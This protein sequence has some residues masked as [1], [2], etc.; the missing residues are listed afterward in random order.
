MLTPAEKEVI[1]KGMIVMW[2]IWS[3]ILLSLFM[4]VLIC[5][6]VGDQVRQHSHPTV[7]LDLLRNILYA[8]SAAELVISFF[9]RKLALTVRSSAS[10]QAGT[11]GLPPATQTTAVGKYTVSMIIALA[12]SEAIGIYG[13]ILYFIGDTFQTLYT[14][15]GIAVIAVIFY[16]PKREDVETLTEHLKRS[17]A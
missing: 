16:R 12:L 5:H 1:D 11:G 13:L 7:S 15:I 17:T 10:R 8:V 6:F 3:A 9:L 4:Y 2:F 14:F